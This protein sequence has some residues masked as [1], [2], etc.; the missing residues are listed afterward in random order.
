M[1]L[2]DPHGPLHGEPLC[3]GALGRK[4]IGMHA[5]LQ[6]APTR[7]QCSRVELE[8]ARQAE[9]REV[10]L[11]ELHASDACPTTREPRRPRAQARSGR[12]T[13]YARD[14]A[15]QCRQRPRPLPS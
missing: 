7:A 5:R 15:M 2:V 11:V 4:T 6:V 10:V 12:M 1:S 9:K 14:M 3:R 13:V 8:A